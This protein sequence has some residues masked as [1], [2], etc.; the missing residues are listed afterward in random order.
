V[1]EILWG[2]EDFKKKKMDRKLYKSFGCRYCGVT[3]VKV[4]GVREDTT[5]QTSK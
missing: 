3:K 1:R 2:E 5:K 4:W